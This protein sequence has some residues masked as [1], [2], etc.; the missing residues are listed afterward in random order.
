MTW[1]GYCWWRCSKSTKVPAAGL[2]IS[3]WTFAN[4]QNMSQLQCRMLCTN[5][6]LPLFSIKNCEMQE[7]CSLRAWC[8]NILYTS[9]SNADRLVQTSLCHAQPQHMM[10]IRTWVCMWPGASR[11]CLKVCWNICLSQMMICRP[12]L[13][14]NNCNI[15]QRLSEIGFKQN[16]PWPYLHP[17]P[18]WRFEIIVSRVLETRS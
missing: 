18:A 1:R 17:F 15:K 13:L 4:F 12:K 9:M 10:C 7:Y 11:A 14:S 5:K 16:S 6:S 2:V 8:S 3:C